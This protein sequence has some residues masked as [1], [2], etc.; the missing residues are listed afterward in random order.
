ML[1]GAILLTTSGV[2]LAQ[3]PAPADTAAAVVV[4]GN[5]P[6]AIAPD[7]AFIP[8]FAPR[9]SPARPSMSSAPAVARRAISAA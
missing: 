5:N 9:A 1:A 3:I 4:E 2:L 6:P 7:A 8:A